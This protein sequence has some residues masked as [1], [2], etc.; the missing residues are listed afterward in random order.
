MLHVLR[1]KQQ[2]YKETEK[3]RQEQTLNEY[4]KMAT[5]DVDD[6]GDMTIV[7]SSDSVNKTNPLSTFRNPDTIEVHCTI[8][9]I[10]KDKRKHGGKQFYGHITLVI[11]RD[12]S[13]IQETYHYGMHYPNSEAPS[14]W[15]DK[16]TGMAGYLKDLKAGTLLLTYKKHLEYMFPDHNNARTLMLQ[17]YKWCIESCPD[18]KPVAAAAKRTD[19]LTFKATT[20]W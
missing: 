7:Y 18:S 2:Q 20:S 6:I 9:R 4:K 14:F 13:D 11:N 16:I 17:Y 10:P 12:L 15:C 8:I 19:V 1:D 5:Y 3:T